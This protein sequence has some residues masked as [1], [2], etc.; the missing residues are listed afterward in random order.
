MCTTIA[1]LGGCMDEAGGVASNNGI[2]GNNQAILPQPDC[3]KGCRDIIGVSVVPHVSVV[4]EL[5]D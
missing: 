2:E 1:G 4:G 3:W 5:R